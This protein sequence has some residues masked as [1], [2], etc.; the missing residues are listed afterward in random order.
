MFSSKSKSKVKLDRVVKPK[1]KPVSVLQ[2]PSNRRAST[3]KGI[4]CICSVSSEMVDLREAVILDVSRTGA[5]IRFRSR[6]T[7][8]PVIRVKAAR[9]GL[10]RRAR[11]VW[12]SGFDAGLEFIPDNRK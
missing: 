5:R 9:I 2:P 12:Q 10:N 11:V 6:G 8:P 1:P 7:L 4:W 3:R